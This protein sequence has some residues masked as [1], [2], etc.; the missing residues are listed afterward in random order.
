MTRIDMATARDERKRSIMQ[1]SGNVFAGLG[2]A[3]AG[4]RQIKVRLAITIND[5]LQ[6]RRLSLLIEP[7]L[8]EE[9][10]S[11]AIAGMDA[12]PRQDTRGEE[13]RSPAHGARLAA[14]SP[15]TLCGTANVGTPPCV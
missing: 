15:L 1:R 4:A 10:E 13:V 11:Q 2:F 7:H 3:D 6:R 9:I 14:D 8:R 5:V 12:D